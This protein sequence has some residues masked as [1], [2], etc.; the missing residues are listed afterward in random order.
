M[1][2]LLPLVHPSPPSRLP[3]SSATEL[4]KI[5]ASSPSSSFSIPN[6]PGFKKWAAKL[7]SRS[8]NLALSASLALG[9]ALGG[10]CLPSSP[11]IYVIPLYLNQHL[12]FACFCCNFFLIGFSIISVSLLRSDTRISFLR[13]M[14]CQLV[15]QRIYQWR[16]VCKSKNKMFEIKGI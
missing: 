4:P 11:E 5:R 9:L 15:L 16:G 8:L 7:R 1:T 6:P 13:Y 12:S 3:L 10:N 14:V 2:S